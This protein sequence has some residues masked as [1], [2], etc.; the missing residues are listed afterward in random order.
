MAEAVLV[1]KAESVWSV[2]VSQ[3]L[4]QFVHKFI[5]EGQN[6]FQVLSS[7]WLKGVHKWSKKLAFINCQKSLLC[8]K[9][10]KKLIAFTDDKCGCIWQTRGKDFAMHVLFKNSF[11]STSTFPF[12]VMKNIFFTDYVDTLIMPECFLHLRYNCHDLYSSV[13]IYII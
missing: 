10:E 1:C 7:Q 11:H 5:T 6:I 13:T 4:S 2:S 12:H 8:Y 3:V 9:K